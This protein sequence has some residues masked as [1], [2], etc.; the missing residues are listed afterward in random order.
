MSQN[1]FQ[2]AKNGIIDAALNLLI[3]S[4][5]NRLKS[6]FG[7]S[8]GTLFPDA[9][10]WPLPGWDTSIVTPAV[11]WVAPNDIRATARGGD[12]FSIFQTPVGSKGG[13]IS[14]LIHG[15]GGSQG[16]LFYNDPVAVHAAYAS[17]Y[18][19]YFGAD[20]SFY[21]N[22]YDNEAVTTTINGMDGSGTPYVFPAGGTKVTL[23]WRMVGTSVRVS[24][25]VD[26]VEKAV[27]VDP[28]PMSPLPLYAAVDPYYSSGETVDFGSVVVTSFG[29]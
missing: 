22:R 6:W 1:A 12:G 11:E 28:T 27:Y 5:F 25:S 2:N 8:F 29:S 15:P 21:F 26:D 10:T 20:G 7:I 24:F 3:G 4:P 19:M 16:L 23:T 9:G 14:W 18:Q 17:I 13:S